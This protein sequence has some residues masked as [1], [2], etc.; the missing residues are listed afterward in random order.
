MDTSTMRPS[1]L[2]TLHLVSLSLLLLAFALSATAT[3]RPQPR[4]ID[5]FEDGDLEASSGLSWL[6]LAD[7]QFGGSSEAALET[8]AEGA[9]DSHHAMRLRAKTTD[10]SQF[11]VASVWVPIQPQGLADDLTAFQGLRF[12]VRS[13]GEQPFVIGARRGRG[14][15]INYMH[16]HVAKAEWTLVEVPFTELKQAPGPTQEAWTASDVSWIGF[17]TPPGF[18]GA[19]TLDVDEVQFF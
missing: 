7:D 18:I 17:S 10:E 16:Q 8:L 1:R 19:F 5:N 3:E 11:P 6:A 13:M 4:L 14:M 12:Y 2:H 15:A 9:A